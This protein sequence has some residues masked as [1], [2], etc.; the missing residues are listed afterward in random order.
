MPTRPRYSRPAELTLRVGATDLPFVKN[1]LGLGAGHPAPHVPARLVVD[2]HVPLGGGSSLASLARGA[3]VPFVIDPETYYLQD[4]QHSGAK[5]CRTPFGKP[6][7]C[8]ALDMA[9]VVVQEDLVKGVVDYQLD[10][11]ATSV[12]APYFHIERPDS[13]WANVQ[14]DVWDRTRAYLA[15]EKINL[16]VIAVVALGWRCLHP[17]Q[18]MPRLSGLWDSLAALNPAEIALAASKVHLGARPQDRIAELLMAVRALSSDYKITMWQQG[19]LGETCVIEGASGYE[20]GIGWREKCDLQTRKAQQ[21]QPSN[22]HPSARPVY[23]SEMGRSVP[24]PRLELARAKRRTWAG[25]VCPSP[26]CCAPGGQDLLGDARRH[27]VV[28][29]AR[30]LETLSATRT[31]QWRWNHVAQRTLRGL[32]IAEAL[33]AL[34]PASSHIP[35]I[36]LN[37]LEAILTVANTRRGRRSVGRRTA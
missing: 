25:L 34:A 19:L 20:C 21:R 29:R 15:R 8:S 31:T 9:N 24:K 33:N 22:G 36:D 3:G 14:A 5:W 35:R 32:E 27:T 6:A 2:A 1:L 18:G 28:A 26:D 17:L 10:H 13:Q 12:I 37:S 7:A 23:I 16:P 4:A 30:D 11:G